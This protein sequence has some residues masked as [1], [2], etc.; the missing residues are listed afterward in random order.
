[1]NPVQGLLHPRTTLRASPS[2]NDPGATSLR[3][4][5]AATTRPPR[6]RG[7]A[8]AI[9]DPTRWARLPSFLA[10]INIARLPS[11]SRSDTMEIVA[12]TTAS[13]SRAVRAGTRVSNGRGSASIAR[14]RPMNTT[15]A[16]SPHRA[17]FREEHVRSKPRMLGS[18]AVASSTPDENNAATDTMTPENSTIAVT[19]GSHFVDQEPARTT[20]ARTTRTIPSG[21]RQ[22]PQVMSAW[23][24]ASRANH[25]GSASDRRSPHLDRSIGVPHSGHIPPG[26]RPFRS[27][28]HLT[29]SNVGSTVTI[30]SRIVSSV[31]HSGQTADAL[32]LRLY[33]HVGHG[34]S[35]SRRK[36]VSTSASVI[37][38]VT[39]SHS[40]ARCR[41]SP[42]RAV[43]SVCLGRMKRNVLAA[44]ST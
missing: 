30:T 29:Q 3:I 4:G 15:W 33:S 24:R 22:M 44:A 40:P 19:I 11:H 32:S 34:R 5:A 14:A 7:I 23:P 13:R 10:G 17:S 41:M 38:G 37:I 42:A 21:S 2:R 31:P 18:W 16:I 1:M 36:A 28:R 39:C 27:Y 6:N 35:R 12:L 26:G 43:T 8:Q 25:A 9:E 20:I